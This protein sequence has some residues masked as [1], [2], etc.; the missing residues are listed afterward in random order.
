MKLFGKR[1]I[2]ITLWFVLFWWIAMCFLIFI[3]FLGHSSAVSNPVDPNTPINIIYFL[4]MGSIG[5]VMI[6]VAF[7]FLEILFEKRVFRTISYG[8]LILAKSTVYIFIFTII[9]GLLSIRNYQ[10]NFGYFD[11]QGWKGTFLNLNLLVPI[12]YLAA[13]SILLNFIKEVSL[14][15]GQGNLWKMLIGKF[16][17]P[18]E[19]ERILMFLDMRS[20]TTIAEKLGHIKYSQLIQDC[21][22]DLAI[23]R[24]QDAKIYQYVG[25]EAV[26]SWD[27]AGGLRNNNCINAFYAFKDTLGKRSD[28]YKRKYGLTP[29]FKAGL[30]MGR[31]TVAE[32]GQIK[33][34]IAFHGDT[35]NTAARIQG[36]CNELDSEL[37]I[38]ENLASYLTADANFSSE[39]KDKVSLR[40]KQEDIT[41]YSVQREGT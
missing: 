9:M 35:V 1:H 5:S 33:K 34:E 32:V 23:V 12:G 26:L 31:V 17:R 11:F 8:R 30:N 22:N 3:R 16:H 40:G 6:G 7:G 41:I 28:Y 10:L 37:L 13:A 2:K 15:F 39:A 27:V 24:K 36:K 38:S 14:K 18:K 20:S 19:E 25:D 21:F 4:R 29:V